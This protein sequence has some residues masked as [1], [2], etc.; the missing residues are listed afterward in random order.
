MEFTV[1]NAVNEELLVFSWGYL[2][3]GEGSGNSMAL[4]FL[5]DVL[6]IDF[7]AIGEDSDS[8]V[9]GKV[10][11][12]LVGKRL[13]DDSDSEFHGG[14]DGYCGHWDGGSVYGTGLPNL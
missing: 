11:K 10:V 6:A 5:Q 1:G 2:Q 9:S 4:V 14:G 7:N 8:K 12:I 13:M 3:A